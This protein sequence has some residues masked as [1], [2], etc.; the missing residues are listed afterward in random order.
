MSSTTKNPYQIIIRPIVTEKSVSD[1]NSGKYIF[2]VAE[3]ANKFEIAWAVEQ[4][5]KE[6]KN[7]VNVVSV[8][9]I[10]VHGKQRRGRFFR[11]VN[12]GKSSDWRK[13]IVTLKQGQTIDLVEG[14]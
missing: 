7:T 9:T 11:R 1:S 3:D 12:S 2:R 5:Q 10:K 8:N 4:I 6:L 14:V 13:A